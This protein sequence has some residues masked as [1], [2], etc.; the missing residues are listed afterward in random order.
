MLALVRQARRRML[1]NELFAQG[2]AACCAAL[3]AFILLLLIGTQVLNW[4]WTVLIPAAAL[5]LGIWSAL[6]RLPS[7]YR[8]AQIVDR[9]MALSDTLSTALYYSES[10]YPQAAEEVRRW[11]LASAEQ[12]ARGVDVRRAVPYRVPRAAYLMAALLLV[13]SSLFALRYGLTRTLDLKQPLAAILRQQFGWE[14]RPETARENHRNTAKKDDPD[15]PS[16]GDEQA[17]QGQPQPEAANDRNDPQDAAAQRQAEPKNGAQKDGKQAQNGDEKGAEQEPQAEN[18]EANDPNNQDNHGQPGNKGDQQQSA[19]SQQSASSGENSSLISKM[20]DAFQNLL[21]H[22]KPPNSQ[23]SPQQA[24]DQSNRQQ[25]NGRQNG[26]KQQSAKNA[27]Q[28]NGEQSG[29]PQ[30]GQ[31]G[32]QA[33]AQRDPQGKGAG[34]S[35]SQQASK[36]PGSGI[37]SQDGDK[38]IKQA[39]QLAA[40]GKISEILGKRSANISGEATVEVQSTSQQLHTAYV[41]RGAQH[42]QGGAEITRDEV[43]VALQAYV[44]QYFEQI[45][46]QPQASVQP[47]K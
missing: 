32:D 39:E 12:L 36:Q 47:K 40:M 18:A 15:D 14:P 35:D 44:E 41:Q 28:Q 38:S 11:Q 10:P 22:V 23:P 9:R 1:H 43:P 4:Q 2:A 19:A 8:T 45:R 16:A 29:D 17:E 31:T 46:K 13:A 42:T 3:A 34:K 26:N 25:A 6:R 20:K 27:Q 24:S 21:S 5:G 7:P 37:G 33:N 30:D